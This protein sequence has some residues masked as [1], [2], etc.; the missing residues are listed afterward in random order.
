MIRLSLFEFAL[1]F[2][3]AGC[4][5]S[6]APS[7][8]TTVQLADGDIAFHRAPNGRTDLDLWIGTGSTPDSF[9]LECPVFVN[10]STNVGVCA[11]RVTLNTNTD[12]WV[13]VVPQ[14]GVVSGDPT[15]TPGL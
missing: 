7:I 11:G 6:T 8:P 4:N 14:S 10:E 5:N 3:L 2:S 13:Y 12:Y 1:V 15:T 9:V